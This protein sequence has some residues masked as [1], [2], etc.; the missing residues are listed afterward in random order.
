MWSK[1][2]FVLV[3]QV[4]GDILEE[5]RG[6]FNWHRFKRLGSL[7]QMHRYAKYHLKVLGEGSARK[8]YLLSSGKVLKI[9]ADPATTY[10]LPSPRGLAQNR[11]EVD[12]FTDPKTGPIVAKV[13]DAHDDFYWIVM[14]LAKEITDEE[15]LIEAVGVSV[16]LLDDITTEMNVEDGVSVWLD[17]QI[18]FGGF[19]PDDSE[20]TDEELIDAALIS[21]YGFTDPEEAES[22]LE[23][24]P[25]LLGV[26]ALINQGVAGDLNVLE[27]YGITSEGRV[28][29]FDYGFTDAVK[30][31]YW[32]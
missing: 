29:V 14:E 27:H 3:E 20:L 24:N 4:L 16:Q 18:N 15:E 17:R 22:T 11:A 31:L 19:D 26:E 30:P 6:G 9:A 23:K 7:E 28:V 10:H 5:V 32:S 25:F 21:H 8:V 2:L 12:L 1:L 13:L